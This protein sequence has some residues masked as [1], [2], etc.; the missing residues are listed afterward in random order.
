[1][2]WLKMKLISDSHNRKLEYRLCLKLHNHI[3]SLILKALYFLKYDLKIHGS[4]WL[5]SNFECEDVILLNF[6]TKETTQL[7][8]LSKI[9]VEYIRDIVCTISIFFLMFILLVCI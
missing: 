2:Q 7:K 6:I 1:M 4:E 5:D 3:I 8:S 9:Y